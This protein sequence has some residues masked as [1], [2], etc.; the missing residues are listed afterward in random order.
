MHRKG[1]PRY[2]AEE[3][4][5]TN[6]SPIIFSPLISEPLERKKDSGI[7]LESA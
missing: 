2:E 1:F 7:E 4:F 6:F 5:H 3:H